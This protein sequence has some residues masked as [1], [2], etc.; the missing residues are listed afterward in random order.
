M[1]MDK[2]HLFI[3]R[4]HFISLI[5]LG[6]IFD[7]MLITILRGNKTYNYHLG[8]KIWFILRIWIGHVW[9]M[10]DER[11]FVLRDKTCPWEV[12]AHL[13]FQSAVDC[14][15]W[16]LKARKEV[17]LGSPFLCSSL[18]HPRSFPSLS[19]DF[20]EADRFSLLFV[21]MYTGFLFC[22][23]F[24]VSSSFFFPD[25][26]YTEKE[27]LLTSNLITWNSSIVPKVVK[28]TAGWMN[29]VWIEAWFILAQCTFF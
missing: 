26:Q 18:S 6:N 16:T 25:E 4:L 14:I 13:N 23:L 11:I 1:L 8:Y 10:K 3:Y 20:Q 12:L 17:C 21:F 19:F 29:S 9:K 7:H 22:F 15:H 24:F 28:Q 5:G 2:F 27:L